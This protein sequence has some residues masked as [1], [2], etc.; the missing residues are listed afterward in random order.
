MSD[1][2][3]DINK[4][5]AE[6]APKKDPTLDLRALMQTPTKKK[7]E[8]ASPL[9]RAMKKKELGM[10][11]ENEELRKANEPLRNIA[12]S[13]ER[14][15]EFNEEVSELEAT[16]EKASKIAVI[17]KPQNQQ[18]DVEM[19]DEISRTVLNDDGTVTIPEGARFI[20][21]KKEL[22]ENA[23]YMSLKDARVTTSGKLVNAPENTV[24]PEKVQGEVVEENTDS[25]NDVSVQD[26]EKNK[27][28]QVLIDKT[29]YG[30]DVIMNEY[31]DK[32]IR[33]ATVIHLTEVEDRELKTMKLKRD[34]ENDMS[35]VETVAK[36]QLAMSKSKMVFPLSGFKGELSA[37]SIGEFTDISLD[38]TSESSDDMI[39]F[40]KLWK[41]CSTI[42]NK[43]MN[44][45]CGKFKDF[46]DFLKKF[47][48]YDTQLATFALLCATKDEDE[49][50]IDCKIRTC[51]KNYTHKYITQTVF[52]F[53]ECD[54]GYINTFNNVLDA[55]GEAMYKMAENSLVRTVKAVKLPSG[56]V[57]EY[58]PISCYEYLYN[59]IRK[60]KELLDIGKKIDENNG[61]SVDGHS[62]GDLEKSI[63]NLQMLQIVRGF[64]IPDKNEGWVQISDSDRVLEYLDKYISSEDYLYVST[65][66]YTAMGAYVPRFT[67]KG[68]KC[69]YCGNYVEKISVDIY[70]LVFQAH[71]RQINTSVTL[72]ELDLF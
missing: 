41:M 54:Q 22:G 28:V 10:V 21:S 35:F 51:L 38:M 49:I 9:E 42:Y 52:D 23:Q 50:G 31:E 16:A 27:L 69:P 36:H 20:R 37:L 17:R 66:V 58:G 67:I 4:E 56:V 6:A 55:T 15:Q 57:L 46:N 5:N 65:I 3:K 25:E 30:K 14:R 70:T 26:D 29:G 47:A 53:G 11:V 8:E 1:E 39:N 43:L 59:Y 40:D 64:R 34:L 12:D 60:I 32:A 68:L 71:Q 63:E 18:E 19:M 62:I 33:S 72:K 2:I 7:E 45:S 44:V 13:D 48:F 24:Q 61:E